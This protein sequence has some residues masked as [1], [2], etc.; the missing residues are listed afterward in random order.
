MKV[1]ASK[2]KLRSYEGDYMAK[3]RQ[4]QAIVLD[5]LKDHPQVVDVQDLSELRTFQQIDSD[6]LFLTIDG[7][8]PLAEIKVDEHVGVSNNIAF[9]IVRI[10]H[11]TTDP[12]N[13]VTLGWSVYTAA[14]WIFY[15]GPV[16]A[17]V[18]QFSA[19]ALR[20]GFQRYTDE[21]RSFSQLAWV[22]TDNIKSTLLAL[23]PMRYFGSDDYRVH[24]AEIY[25]HRHLS[26][27]GSG[28]LAQNRLRFV[29]PVSWA[30][31]SP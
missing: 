17:F 27:P 31:T 20:R 15:Y 14:P 18:Y 10:N 7:L 26:P 6:A 25:A 23:V 30:G 13:C 9:E 22:D 21:A 28:L 3:G 4:G 12:R 5:L 19:D 11:R 29:E 16:F 24:D 2:Y 1:T 8:R